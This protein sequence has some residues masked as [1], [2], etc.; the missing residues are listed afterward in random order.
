MEFWGKWGEKFKGNG[1]RW[2]GGR[3]QGNEERD[4]GKKNAPGAYSSRV[5]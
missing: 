4:G 2:R 3:D 1:S 5:I